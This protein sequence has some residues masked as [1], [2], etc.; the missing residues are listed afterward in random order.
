MS[1]VYFTTNPADFTQLEGLYI[2]ERNPPAFIRGRDSSVV[3]FAGRCVRGPLTPQLITDTGRFLEIYGGRDFGAGGA[4]IGQVWFALVNKQFGAVVVRRVAAAAAASATVTLDDTAGVGGTNII[5]ITA[6]SPG[7]WGNDIRATVE[8]ATDAD[9]THF[10]LR[11]KWTGTEIL[12]QNCNTSGSND[13]LLSL[14]GTDVA[15]LVTLTKV[16]NGRP[17]NQSLTALTGGTEGSLAASDYNAGMDDIAVFPGV[18]VCLHPEITPTQATTNGHL[19]TLAATVADR[20]FLTWSGVDQAPSAEVAQVA[21]EITTRTDRVWWFYNNAFTVDPDTDA[22]VAQGPHVWAASILSQTDVDVHL[23]AFDNLRFCAGVKRLA[24]TALTRADLILLRNAGISTLERLTEGFLF[25]SAVT[26]LLTPGKTE[27]ARRRMVD[28]LQLSASD[29]LRT[30]VRA[31][32]IAEQRALMKSELT[33]FSEGLKDASRIVELFSIDQDSV[34][35]PA[36]RG[37]GEE[38]ILWR[39]KLIGHI[40][41]LVLETEMGTGVTIEQQAA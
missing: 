30:Y 12:L 1:D 32:N 11:V 5:T 25:R 2:S 37:R 29:R 23:G 33:S 13:N 36:G 4:L 20:V 14:I 41:F 6:S 24:R 39:V 26:T 19:V 22:E 28:F 17:H 10:N 27:I 21:S 18:S 3:G 38:H 9:A 7:A 34:N 31:K 15:N 40:L 8:A 16:G 35:T